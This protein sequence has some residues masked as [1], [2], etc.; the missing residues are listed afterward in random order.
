MDKKT[1]AI[2]QMSDAQIAAYSAI[3]PDGYAHAV[4]IEHER[5]SGDP[6]ATFE[7]GACPICGH[8]EHR[9]GEYRTTNENDHV[10][11]RVYCLHCLAIERFTRAHIRAMVD[12]KPNKANERMSFVCEV[13]PAPNAD[14]HA[15]AAAML[16]PSRNV[17]DY[18]LG[19]WY[20]KNDGGYSSAVMRNL[21]QLNTR[22]DSVLDTCA[23]GT[24]TLD[25]LID[26]AHVE[27]LKFEFGETR[28]RNNGRFISNKD[29]LMLAIDW[30]VGK[31]RYEGRGCYYHAEN[32]A[33]AKIERKGVNMKH[34]FR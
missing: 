5:M 25:V 7:Y 6:L 31:Y 10:H 15:L 28:R 17:G 12:C 22:M 23:A 3:V 32:A 27:T 26:G 9:D 33:R 24:I 20:R 14:N 2:A 21:K 29:A 4:I 18:T 13:N 11:A 16:T 19:R 8:T 34:M 1:L 30:A